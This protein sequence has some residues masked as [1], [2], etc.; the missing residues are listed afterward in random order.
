MRQAQQGLVLHGAIALR[1]Q[2][3]GAPFAI[4]FAADIAHNAIDG[5]GKTPLVETLDTRSTL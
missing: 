5:E 2:D 3:R 4:H 1:Y